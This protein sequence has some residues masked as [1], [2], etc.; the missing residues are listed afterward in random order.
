MT[1]RGILIAIIPVAFAALAILFYQALL[2]GGDPS[3]VP[4]ALIGRPVPEFALPPVEG[5]AGTAGPLPG[6]AASDLRQGKISVVNVWASWCGPCRTEHPFLMDLSARDDIV[7]TAINYKD[8]PE[9]ARRFLGLL[10]NPFAAVGSDRDGRTAVNWGVYGVPETF[11]VDGQG[12]IRYKHVG[13][14]TEAA[15]KNDFLPAIAAAAAK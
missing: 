15:L 13:A 9:N 2:R 8:E 11:I 6:L 12:T 10:G 5:L 1:A 3:T 4:S 7:V 14:L